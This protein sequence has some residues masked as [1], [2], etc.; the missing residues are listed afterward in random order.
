MILMKRPFLS[1][2]FMASLLGAQRLEKVIRLSHSPV[3]GAFNLRNNKLYVTEALPGKISVIDCALDSAIKVFP[4]RIG[5]SRPVLW[6]P[7]RNKFYT[8]EPEG[9]VLVFDAQSDTFIDS[10][11][12]PFSE[13]VDWSYNPKTRK[14]YITYAGGVVAICEDGD[15]L[16][17][18]STGRGAV[19]FW[20]PVNNLMYWARTQGNYLAYIDVRPADNDTLTI[21]SIEAP[22]HP[23]LYPVAFWVRTMDT[24]RNLLLASCDTLTS[25]GLGTASYPVV[26]DANRDTILNWYPVRFNYCWMVANPGRHKA[27][28]LS[29][30]YDHVSVLDYL[31]GTFTDVH[32][33]GEVG[34]FGVYSSA[35]DRLYVLIRHVLND[36]EIVVI[37]GASDSIIRRFEPPFGVNWFGSNSNSN[38]LYVAGTT[39]SVVQVYAESLTGAP[40]KH[41]VREDLSPLVLFP[42]PAGD[43][44]VLVGSARIVEVTIYDAAGNL[45]R[46]G[47]PVRNAVSLQGITSGVFFVRARLGNTESV[48][49][50]VV[51]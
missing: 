7:S 22:L 20:N 28:I 12:S 43:Y 29:S 31:N 18:A 34:P 1:L 3:N 13:A 45:V 37:D 33:G 48:Q 23:G 26:I 8:V 30:N 16:L 51:R 21:K 44:F 10:I 41:D 40:E 35:S 25:G 9:T 32:T 36:G 38:K 24:T 50:L 49:K 5:M 47:I 15:S 14:I 19:P 39:D 46:R 4:V 11:Q 27:Y 6:T 42:N 2:L 17:A